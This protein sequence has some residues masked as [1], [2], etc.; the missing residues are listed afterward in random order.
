MFINSIFQQLVSNNNIFTNQRI[1]IFYFI[2]GE[3]SVMGD[4]LQS[5]IDSRC[6]GIALTGSALFVYIKMFV[7]RK[8]HFFNLFIY[9]REF[10]RISEFVKKNCIPFYFY[11]QS[12]LIFI[13]QNFY[14]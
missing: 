12:H 3:L 8:K 1:K 11:L 5:K 2:P 4:E 9:Q 7:K 13:D 14:S 6:T 10:W